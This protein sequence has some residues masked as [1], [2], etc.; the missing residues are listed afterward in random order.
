MKKSRKGNKPHAAETL[1]AADIQSLWSHELLG[2]ATSE[3]L[4]NS[5]WLMLTLH[6]DL[7]R[8][9]EHYELAYGD[10]EV[11]ETTDGKSYVQLNEQDTKTRTGESSLDTR[12]FQPK[13]W[14]TPENP[15]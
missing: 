5:V 1:E 3:S 10:F 13:M 6:L 8:R 12:A 2:D 11:K 4:L 7:R 14:S 9:D 15:D